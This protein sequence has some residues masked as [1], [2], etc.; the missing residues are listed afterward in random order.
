[1]GPRQAGPRQRQH[2]HA[3]PSRPGTPA[4]TARIGIGQRAAL[5]RCHPGQS[6]FCRPW[7]RSGGKSCGVWREPCAP[8][9]A[10]L[11]VAV[12]GG[13]WLLCSW[14][15]SLGVQLSG[16]VCAHHPPD[17]GTSCQINGVSLGSRR[18]M[19]LPPVAQKNSTA[20]APQAG[21]SFGPVTPMPPTAYP[22]VF[23]GEAG[24]TCFAERS[25]RFIKSFQ[26][27]GPQTSAKPRLG[28]ERSSARQREE[29]KPVKS[30]LECRLPESGTQDAKTQKRANTKE[31]GKKNPNR[32][33]VG[34][35]HCGLGS[36]E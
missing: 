2:R 21:R 6:M 7:H 19:A 14:K 4:C 32:V 11:R 28:L 5:R 9:P 12:S 22:Q 31:A 15:G 17:G 3:T 23:S 10:P 35:S 34:I 36:I 25:G 18:V 27:E 29:K 16:S 13:C 8:R 30:S 26:G 1:M 24:T 33:R 20:D